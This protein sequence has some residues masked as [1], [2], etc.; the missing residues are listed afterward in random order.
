MPERVS[1]PLLPPDT[2]RTVLAGAIAALT[3]G[4]WIYALMRPELRGALD[5]QTTLWWVEQITGLALVIVCIAIV[6]RQRAFFTIAFWLTAYSL[7]FDL[8]RWLFG[9][10]SGRPTIPVA[11]VLYALFLW[12]L[13]MTRRTVLADQ[14]SAPPPQ[15][16]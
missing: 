6:L 13:R 15:S 1:R 8:M 2:I 16:V 7:L 9:Y 10:A 14:A 12:R 5:M 3:I 4:G 11:L